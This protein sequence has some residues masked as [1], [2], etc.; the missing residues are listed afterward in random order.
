MIEEILLVVQILIG[1]LGFAILFVGTFYLLERLG[2]DKGKPLTAIAVGIPPMTTIAYLALC[3]MDG[4]TKHQ[5]IPASTLI[6]PIA[7]PLFFWTGIVGIFVGL[8]VVILLEWSPY[9]FKII[10]KEKRSV[11]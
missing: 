11:K 10:K 3:C 6:Q 2:N 5:T 4:M 8:S 7:Y 9:K 1:G